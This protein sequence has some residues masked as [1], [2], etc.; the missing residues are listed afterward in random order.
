MFN[1]LLCDRSIM[2]NGKINFYNDRPIFLERSTGDPYYNGCI[3]Y[4][5]NDKGI[6]A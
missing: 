4:E 1:Y 2:D 5:C 3:K 6:I